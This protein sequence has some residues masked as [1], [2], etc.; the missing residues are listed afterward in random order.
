MDDVIHSRANASG[1]HHI[2]RTRP[3]TFEEHRMQH[4][5]NIAQRAVQVT[6]SALAPL[7]WQPPFNC[8]TMA[9]SS[10]SPRLSSAS[11]HHPG[12]TKDI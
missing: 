6:T 12:Q 4:K 8:R 11:T 7:Q 10:R 2:K 9:P 5:W 3:R 1:Q